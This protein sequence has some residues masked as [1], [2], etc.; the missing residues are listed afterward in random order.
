MAL[1]SKPDLQVRLKEEVGFA[2]PIFY[3]LQVKGGEYSR[4]FWVKLPGFDAMQT[5]EAYEVA[6]NWCIEHKAR[7]VH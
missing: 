4:F 6:T 3:N 5:G 1:F 2:G 7:F